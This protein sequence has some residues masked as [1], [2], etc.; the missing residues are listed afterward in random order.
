[1]KSNFEFLKKFSKISVNNSAKKLNIDTS[2]V[3][4]GRTSNENYE[5]IKDDI[6]LDIGELFIDDYTKKI[7]K[8]YINRLRSENLNLAVEY[9]FSDIELTYTNI[10]KIL[11]EMENK[12]CQ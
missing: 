12:L 6:M 1:M 11:E 8:S 2:N 4:S 5:K 3:L 10:S 9:T 7:I